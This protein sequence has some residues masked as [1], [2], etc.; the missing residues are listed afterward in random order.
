[1]G[2]VLKLRAGG[3]FGKAVLAPMRLRI[4][5]VSHQSLINK[6]GISYQFS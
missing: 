2:H 3:L 5:S 6:D 4:H 1:V